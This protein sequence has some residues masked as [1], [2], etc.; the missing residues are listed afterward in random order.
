MLAG[1]LDGGDSARLSRA[2]V[3]GSQVAASVSVDYSL[4]GRLENLLTLAA[5]PAPS[6]STEELEQELRAQTGACAKY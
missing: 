2:L 5:N 4:I 1:V 6:R 3:R